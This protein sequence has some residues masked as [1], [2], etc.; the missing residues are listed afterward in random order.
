VA[1]FLKK[2]DLE[3]GKKVQYVSDAAMEYLMNYYWPGNIRE[4]ENAV[5]R[6]VILCKSDTLEAELFPIPGQK[7]QPAMI[8]LKPVVGADAAP[9]EGGSLSA[10]VEALEKNL[11]QEALHA[12]KGNQRKA[13]KALGVTERILG[14]KIK[15]YGLR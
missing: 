3:N 8:H 6:A 7:G 11:I 15:N 1:H 13:A 4:L 9:G 2:S 12:Q 14:Y 5:E 10:A